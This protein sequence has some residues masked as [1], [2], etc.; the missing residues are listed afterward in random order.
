MLPTDAA[1]FED[2]K[3]APFA[4]KYAADEK[5][6]FEDYAAAHLKL[7]ELGSKFAEGT[8]VTL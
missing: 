7:S 3:F 6:F 8:G 1:V 5:A 4:E 2:E